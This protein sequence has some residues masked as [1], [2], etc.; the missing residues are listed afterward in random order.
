[1]G[2]VDYALV[3]H[4]SHLPHLS[5]VATMQPPHAARELFHPGV[6]RRADERMA[7]AD[8]GRVA[9]RSPGIDDIDLA[10]NAG[11]GVVS[12]LLSA[13][14]LQRVGHIVANSCGVVE[15]GAIDVLSLDYR[16]GWTQAMDDKS[17]EQPGAWRHR[18]RLV[19]PGAGRHWAADSMAH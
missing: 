6:Y 7:I 5:R 11:A 13:I 8:L 19:H 9:Q 16:I 2:N 10:D 18:R 1:M 17:H 4:R 3:F 15:R 12:Q 14:W